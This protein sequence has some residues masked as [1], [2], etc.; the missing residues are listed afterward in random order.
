MIF[1]C[2]DRANILSLTAVNSCNVTVCILT[3]YTRGT[4]FFT[5]V[6][7]LWR[8]VY[9]KLGGALFSRFTVWCYPTLRYCELFRL[10]RFSILY[11]IFLN[12]LPRI[13]VWHSQIL[14]IK[15][16]ILPNWVSPLASA[17]YLSIFARSWTILHQFRLSP[18]NVSI[19]LHP[20]SESLCCLARTTFLWPAR[21]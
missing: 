19:S 8:S 14:R 15:C 20:L 7:P 12:L 16:R 13:N 18:S 3:S 4:P 1:T 2:C 6:H 9:P 10:A 11:D 17:I 21:Q 5:G